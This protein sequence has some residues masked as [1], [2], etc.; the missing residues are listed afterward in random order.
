MFL[1]R[2]PPSHCTLEARAPWGHAT[3]HLIFLS[4]EGPGRATRTDLCEKFP[5]LSDNLPGAGEEGHSAPQPTA[6]KCGLHKSCIPCCASPSPRPPERG[7]RRQNVLPGGCVH[8]TWST[9][10]I[11]DGC[12]DLWWGQQATRYQFNLWRPGEVP[13]KDPKKTLSTEAQRASWLAVLHVLVPWEGTAGR[14]S[15]FSPGLCPV[16]LYLQWL[17]SPRTHVTTQAEQ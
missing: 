6:G 11:L 3:G 12:C 9:R 15:V 8:G 7:L 17:S 14:W 1:E 10:G 2:L 4:H 16:H 5:G 13:V